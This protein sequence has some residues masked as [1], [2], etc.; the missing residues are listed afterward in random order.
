MAIF[1]SLWIGKALSS[2][3]RLCIK[4]FLLNGHGFELFVYEPVGRVPEGCRILDARE[5][6]PESRVF[7]GKK[8]GFGKGTYAGFSDL[9]R[10]KM[11]FDRGGWWV[12]T[13]VVCLTRE[14]PEPPIA[15]ARQDPITVNGAILRFPVAHPAMKFAYD[16]A[17]AEGTDFNWKRIGPRLLTQVV[18]SFELER[19]LVPTQ[20][21]YPLDHRRFG[22]VFRPSKRDEMIARTTGATF[23]HLWTEMFRSVSY[24]K[25][26]RPPAGSYL[27][28]LFDSCGMQD[29]F[30]CEYQITEDGDKARLERSNLGQR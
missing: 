25:D 22:A 10:Y 17:T 9:F 4:S 6:L 5:I 26:C 29:E 21:Y 7:T 8:E 23:L 28:E 24:D 11:L 30:Q 12:D 16:A 2:V 27:R 19:W 14:V 13:D 18:Q 15:L 20:N 1:S 3:E